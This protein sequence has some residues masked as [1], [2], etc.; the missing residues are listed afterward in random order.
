MPLEISTMAVFV[1][2]AFLGALVGRI[3]TF[4]VLSFWLILKLIPLV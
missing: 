2:G 4:T 1:L 3:I